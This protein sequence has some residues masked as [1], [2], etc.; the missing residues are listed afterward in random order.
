MNTNTL[1]KRLREFRVLRGMSQ[2][3][4]AEESQ[5]SLRTI[6]RIEN[7]ES[8]PTGETIKRI[9]TAL[10]VE[11][12]ELVGTD[13]ATPTSDLKGTIVYL[14]RQLSKTHV[15]S[16]QRTLK[17]FITILVDLKSKELSKEKQGEIEAYIVFLELDKIPSHSNELFDEKLI[18]FKRYL[19]T[20][21]RYV[22]HRFYTAI[23]LMFAIPFASGFIVNDHFDLNTR[24]GIAA[25]AITLIGLGTLLDLRMKKNGRSLRL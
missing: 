19:K 9:S 8:I 18:K 12:H 10:D 3:F 23:T 6:Q 20:K 15:K 17:R 2:E 16:E 4:L 24:I 21:L 7:E 25:L 5:V 11:M 14:K 13:T 22:P 1:A